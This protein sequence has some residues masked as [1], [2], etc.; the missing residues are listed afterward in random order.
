MLNDKHAFVHPDAIIGKNVTIS[1]FAYIDSDVVI[2]DNTWVG[3]HATIFAGSRIGSDCKIFPGAVIGAIPQD[4]KFAGEYTTV[5][6]GNK[7]TIR[8]AVTVNRGTAAKG[9]TVVGNNVL[10]MACVHVGHDTIIRNNVIV[11]NAVLFGGEV[12]V[13]D[14]AVIGGGSAIHQFVHIGAH[15]ILAGGSLVNKDIPPYVKAARYPVSYCGINSVGLRRRNFSNETIQQIQDIYRILFI[16]GLNYS[17]ALK[18]IETEIPESN[19]KDE[20]V[21][22]IKN[23]KRGLMKGYVDE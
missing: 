15:V 21:S 12:V 2:G 18:Y 8:E 17:D 11:A 1:P 20:I 16:K 22:F 14:F 13:D 23:S 4:L 7:T 3:P 9:K 5:E 10:L 6:I 19:E